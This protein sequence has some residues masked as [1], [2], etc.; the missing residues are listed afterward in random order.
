MIIVTFGS[1]IKIS[2]KWLCSLNLKRIIPL[3]PIKF[4]LNAGSRED[5]DE[6]RCDAAMEEKSNGSYIFPIIQLE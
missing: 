3:V 6:E 2:K 4:R 1:G 5:F